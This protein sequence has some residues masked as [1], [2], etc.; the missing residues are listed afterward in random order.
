[1]SSF[2]LYFPLGRYTQWFPLGYVGVPETPTYALDSAPSLRVDALYQV[3]GY[4]P[5][6]WR[7]TPVIIQYF[8]G[9]MSM[10]SSCKWLEISRS[11]TIS[12]F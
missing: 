6:F 12:R 7:L 3:G 11:H 5:R 8:T 2:A 4:D 9:C 1:M 10:A